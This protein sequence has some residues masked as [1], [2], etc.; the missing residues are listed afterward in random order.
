VR[1]NRRRKKDDG[2]ELQF[3]E[4]VPRE[5]QMPM[6]D[7]IECPAE[8]ADLFQTILFVATALRAMF[9]SSGNMNLE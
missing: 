1:G 7:R 8:D 9:V 6:M 4:R 5:D 2:F 3:F